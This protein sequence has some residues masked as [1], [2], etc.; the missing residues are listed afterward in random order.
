M[1][2][3]PGYKSHPLWQSAIALTRDAYDLA[4][5]FQKASPEAARRLRKAAVAVPAHVAAA[6][7]G[8]ARRHEQLLLLRGA[9]A[10]LKRL[11]SRAP[12]ELPE[13]LAREAETIELSA[14]FEFGT[15]EA[16]R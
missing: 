9:L 14:L 13:R 2:D 3:R 11:A 15:S 4:G 16:A 7:S 12:G 8:E 1:T 5:R 10:E 6:L